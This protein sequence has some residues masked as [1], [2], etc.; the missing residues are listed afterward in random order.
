VQIDAALARIRSYVFL[1]G[2]A[3]QFHFW[4]GLD[5]IEKPKLVDSIC[6]EMG[7]DDK[8]S[9]LER[10]PK[11]VDDTIAQNERCIQLWSAECEMD[12]PKSYLVERAKLIE[13]FERFEF[14]PHAYERLVR[15]DDKPLLSSA[16]TFLGMSQEL[17]PEAKEVEAVVRMKLKEFVKIELKIKHDLTE[18]DE[19]RLELSSAYEAL[20]AEMVERQAAKDSTTL[21]SAMWGLKKAASY[22][23]YKKGF[24]F[25]GYARAWI[26][27]AID[28]RKGIEGT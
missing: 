21:T 14:R 11:L 3:A 17:T 23:D 27:N 16:I 13:L 5:L 4:K 19:V 9:Y 18:L 8:S 10:L 12:E 6:D 20:A 7:D 2:M 25:P 1:M 28:K 15:Q 22:Y 26:Q 24:G